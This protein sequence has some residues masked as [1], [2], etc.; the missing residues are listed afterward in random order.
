MTRAYL[1]LGGNSGTPTRTLPEALRLLAREDLAIGVQSPMYRTPPWGPIPQPDYVNQVVEVETQR[2]AE[3][4]LALALDV[5]RRLGRD[6]ARED[7]YGPRPIDI[8]ILIFGQER[9]SGPDLIL[10]HPRLLE[11]AF[12]LVPLLDIAPDIEI[13]GILAR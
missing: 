8:D 12:A 9:R 2:T 6:R 13:D 3:D 11:R 4:L 7:R 10:P 1:C 5:E